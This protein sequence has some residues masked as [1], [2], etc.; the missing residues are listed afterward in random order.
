MYVHQD[1]IKQT[2]CFGH[3]TV[4][5]FPYFWTEPFYTWTY[6]DTPVSKVSQLQIVHQ[7]RYDVVIHLRIPSIN[8]EVW[9][10][11]TYLARG[12]RSDSGKL[13]FFAAKVDSDSDLMSEVVTAVTDSTFASC[14]SWYHQLCGML[15]GIWSRQWWYQWQ[16]SWTRRFWCWWWCSPCRTGCLVTRDERVVGSRLKNSHF[17]H[18]NFFSFFAPS[19]HNYLSFTIIVS[20]WKNAALIVY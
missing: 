8:Y 11:D 14:S 3:N 18:R 15:W 16:W 1:R 12:K 13:R 7:N 5:A 20:S 2:K 17:H 4:S 10:L 9:Y 19:W 6:F